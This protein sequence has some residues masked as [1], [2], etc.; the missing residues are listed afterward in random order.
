MS[1]TVYPIG[2]IEEN[3]C[4]L[5]TITTPANVNRVS[6]RPQDP[7]V[8]RNQATARDHSAN[9]KKRILT[10]T[11]QFSTTTFSYTKLCLQYNHVPYSALWRLSSRILDWLRLITLKMYAVEWVSL[12]ERMT[13]RALLG[14]NHVHLGNVGGVISKVQYIDPNQGYSWRKA[15]QE[16]EELHYKDTHNSSLFW[17]S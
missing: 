14:R 12:T 13:Y 16:N 5:I 9:W 3:N 6:W 11:A 10:L 7:Q 8:K 17:A 15:L 2:L 1:H 4:P